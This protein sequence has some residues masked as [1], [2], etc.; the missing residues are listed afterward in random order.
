MIKASAV[1]VLC[2]L[3]V[4]DEMADNPEYKGW[5]GFKPGSWVKVTNNMGSG[6]T[7]VRVSKL[8]ELTD[9]KAVVEDNVT[10]TQGDK[11]N[12]LPA[13]KRE[14]PARKKKI[15]H[16]IL[17][18]GDGEQEVAGKKLA[19][20][21]YESQMKNMKSKAKMWVCKDVPGGLV[22]IDVVKEGEDKPARVTE[23]L[24]WHAE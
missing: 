6:G 22:A 13:K 8:V 2:A 1:A 9:D 12:E 24:E 16:E 4:Q 18:E 11:K 23:V 3:F 19:C 17:A 20:H 14:V 10:I 15:E 5:K 21:W 7:M